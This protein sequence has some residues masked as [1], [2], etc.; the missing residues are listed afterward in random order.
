MFLSRS[1]TL[2][3]GLGCTCSGQQGLSCAWWSVHQNSL[4]WLDPQILKLLFVVHGQNNCLHQLQRA[5]Q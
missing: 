3:L 1:D 2:H 4:W 5:K